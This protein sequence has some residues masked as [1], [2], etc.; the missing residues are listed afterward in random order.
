[1]AIMKNPLQF[2]GSLG[3]LS[4]YTVQGSDKV[5]LRTKGGASKKKIKTSPKFAR[6]RE[7]NSE[8]GRCAK[9]ASSIRAAIWPVK[10]MADYNFT[11]PLIALAKHVQGMDKK[12]ARGKREV[13]F[14]QHRYLLEGF[15]LNR[16]NPFDSV[17]RHPLSCNLNRAAATAAIQLPHLVPG[18]NFRI[19]WQW[20]VFRFVAALGIMD[21]HGRQGNT[22]TGYAV[23]MQTEWHPVL[24]PFPSQILELE[25]SHAALLKSSTFLLSI[26]IETGMPMSN[27]IINPARY[28][29]CAKILAAM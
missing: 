12:N 3:H 8:F 23:L 16:R 17:V 11:P 26:G 28:G 7:N 18:V 27:T 2:T 19:P 15:N 24:Q 22:S 20:P 1:M 29:G 25:F 21:D 5:I 13:A 4:A 14:S 9:V 6:T 10:H